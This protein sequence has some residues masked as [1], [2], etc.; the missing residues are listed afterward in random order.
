MR[1]QY[2]PF[3]VIDFET[4]N[5]HRSSACAIGMVK[6]GADGSVADSYSQLLHP[7]PEVD[8]FNPI[9]I[10]VHGIRPENVQDAPQW[11]DITQTVRSFIGDLPI[12][13]HNMAFDGYVLRDLMH[14]Y[15]QDELTNRRLCTLRLARRLLA[16]D[17]NSKSLDN[18]FHYYFPDSNFAHHKALAD[19]QAA[20]EIFLKMQQ[21]YGYPYLERICPQTTPRRRGSGIALRSDLHPEWADAEDL[22]QRYK[23]SEALVGEHVCI[24]GT[25]KHGQRA[26]VQELVSALHGTP[27]KSL[28]KKTTMLVVGIPDPSKWAEG[29]SASRKLMK[30]V[31]L[32]DAGVPIQ[33]LS[34]DEFFNLL[35]DGS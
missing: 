14:L 18:V 22:I 33:I 21:L 19:A 34:E 6:Y 24:T 23:F 13:A 7:H 12:V 5:E 4:A 17:L 1:E 10:A 27:D 25:L 28:T 35:E 30:A 29:S 11:G 16:D 26:T 8:Y 20:G 32:R 31:A 15:N 9:N 2:N 3:V